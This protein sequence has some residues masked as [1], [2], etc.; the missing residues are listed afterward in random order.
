MR[1]HTTRWE[2]RDGVLGT[3]HEARDGSRRD[4]RPADVTW[5]FGEKGTFTVYPAPGVQPPRERRLFAYELASGRVTAAE[6]SLQVSGVV[7]PEAV[8]GVL[9]GAAVIGYEPGATVTVPRRRDPS[10]RVVRSEEQFDAARSEYPLPVERQRDFVEGE[11][12]SLVLK[13]DRRGRRRF[14]NGVIVARI[15]DCA[16]GACSFRVTHS[17]ARK[18]TPSATAEEIE[19]RQRQFAARMERGG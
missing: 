18:G 12:V 19:M 11:R 16:C 7:T 14:F 2:V 17:V 13:G 3:S 8:V 4:F 6:A 9:S 5:A 1:T 10:G 15:D